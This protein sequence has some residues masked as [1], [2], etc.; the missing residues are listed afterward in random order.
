M[1][2]AAKP[3]EYVKKPVPAA[4]AAAIRADWLAAK[5]RAIARARAATPKVVRVA[6]KLQGV[7]YRWGGTSPSGFDCSGFTQYVLKKVGASPPRDTYGQIGY[8][9]RVANLRS[10]KPGDLLFPHTGHVML[11]IGKGKAIHSPSS[12]RVVHTVPASSRSYIAIRRPP[13][14]NL[15]R[16]AVSV[17]SPKRKPVQHREHR[18]SKN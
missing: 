7:P 2:D 14:L 6:L 11:Y 5:R 13:G 16:S 3:V 9:S 12:G 1:A 18:N 17:K 10:A 15:T 4:Q 8:G